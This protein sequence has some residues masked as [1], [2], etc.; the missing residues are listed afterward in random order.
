MPIDTK[1]AGY[2]ESCKRTQRVRDFAEGEFVV[3]EKKKTY[4]PELGGQTKKEYDAYVQRGFLI[5][6]VEPTAKAIIGCVMRKDGVL[7]GEEHLR[8]DADGNGTDLDQ[9]VSN[10][11]NELLMAGGGG[12]L[13]EVDKIKSYT[14]ECVINWSDRFIILAQKYMEQVGDDIYIEE[15][16][17]EYLELTYDESGYYVQ[18][19]WREVSGK[20]T[21]GEPIYPDSRGEKLKKIPFVHVGAT[22]DP[23]LL[24]LA[25]VNLDQYRMSADLRHGLHWTAIPTWFLFGD[26]R[27][28]EGNQKTL[29][30]GAGSFNQVDDTDGRAE[31]L[32]FTGAGL[33]ALK[34][35]IDDNIKAM[36]SIGAV[37]LT[38][39]ESSGVK[40]AETARI[41]A[42][43]ETATLSNIANIIDDTMNK[44]L[45]IIAENNSRLVAKYNVNRDFIDT[46]LDPQELA[47]LLQAVQSGKM[48]LPTFLYQ[49]ER[50]EL[51]PPDVTA[52]DEADRIAQDPRPFDLEPE[53]A[54]E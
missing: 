5:P 22:K 46:K 27:D 39:G 10:M 52:D 15:E 12:Y 8:D 16:K 6:A 32:E 54:D 9:V 2:E 17:T 23:I 36:A 50:G 7:D 35:A 4:L 34:A 14:K 3:K 37:M 33:G 30:V 1:H 18:Y 21:R 20:L 25:S 28:S 45:E 49:L 40:A 38:N 29:S 26:F 19:V 42:S 53:N 51:L 11:I 44:L 47:V 31:L 41:E 48:S 24:H 13:V 43:S